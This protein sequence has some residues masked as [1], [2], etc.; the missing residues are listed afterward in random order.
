MDLIV[1]FEGRVVLKLSPLV[2]QL[3][4]APRRVNMLFMLWFHVRRP[5]T[6]AETP[7]RARHRNQQQLLPRLEQFDGVTWDL[8]T[9]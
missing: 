8:S 5:K 6:P 1:S 2:C 7:S 3:E 4:A 9:A